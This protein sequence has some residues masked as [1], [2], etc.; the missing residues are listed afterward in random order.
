MDQTGYADAATQTEGVERTAER[1]V[2]EV[3]AAYES[4][5]LRLWST[6]FFDNPNANL[7][8]YGE[9]AGL[10][11]IA[12][13]RFLSLWRPDRS[14]LLERVRGQVRGDDS[15]VTFDTA[16]DQLLP[17]ARD[18]LAKQLT[19]LHVPPKVAERAKDILL[20]KPPIQQWK[21]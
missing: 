11:R 19:A 5:R 9:W 16:S 7:D 17:M 3:I 14:A 12:A 21:M 2:D 15:R 10:I 20:A 1:V 4:G 8:G 13:E 6:N 18:A